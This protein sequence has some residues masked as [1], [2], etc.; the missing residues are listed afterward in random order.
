MKNRKAK[1][2]KAKIQHIPDNLKIKYN[3]HHLIIDKLEQ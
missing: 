3:T 2:E 1:L